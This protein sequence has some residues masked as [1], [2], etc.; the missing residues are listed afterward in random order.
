VPFKGV[1]VDETEEAGSSE[2]Q[3]MLVSTLVFAPQAANDGVVY[4]C[5]ANQPALGPEGLAREVEDKHHLITSPPQV[6]LTV[7]YPPGVPQITVLGPTSARQ[8]GGLQFL[9]CLDTPFLQGGSGGHPALRHLPGQ[10][11]PS[12]QLVPGRG[13]GRHK[14]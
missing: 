13:E 1:G 2:G 3:R 6:A 14:L 8:S 5:E 7:H 11:V 9:L 10:P 12:P 4:R